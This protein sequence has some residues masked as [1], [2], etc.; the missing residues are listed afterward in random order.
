MFIKS[1]IFLSIIIQAVHGQVVTTL[2]EFAW[3]VKEL[4]PKLKVKSFLAGNEDPHFVDASPSFVFKAAKAKLLIKN[5]MQLEMGWLPPVTEQS[6]NVDVQLGGKGHCDAS[7]KVNKI[8]IIENYD[9]SMGDVHPVGNP[10][11]SLSLVEMKNVVEGIATCL[12][13]VGLKYDEKR[14]ENLLKRFDDAIDK[15]KKQLAPLKS[16]KFMVYHIEFNYFFRDFGLKSAGSLEEV[17]G[18]LP[19]AIYLSKTAKKAM[20]QKVALVLASNVSP[21]RYLEKFKDISSVNYVKAQV[22][23]LNQDDFLKHYQV[24]VD[25]VV[26]NV[27]L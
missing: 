12:K 24:F 11:Y 16:K 18:V 10:H 21:D 3:V 8:G 15:I 17:P 20:D 14:K 13:N 1:I 7:N 6:G 23:P 5:G 22:H 2:P 25:E 4:N 26:K 19:S 27:G 9:R